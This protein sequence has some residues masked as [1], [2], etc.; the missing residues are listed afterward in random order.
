VTTIADAR[1]AP[2]TEAAVDSRP[3]Y[4]QVTRDQW[5]AFWAVFLGWVVDSFD[6]NILAFIVIDIKESF[7]IDNTLLYTGG[8]GGLGMNRAFHDI[9]I[10]QELVDRLGASMNSGRAIFLYGAAGTGKSARRTEGQQVF[11]AP[12]IPVLRP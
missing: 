2:T 8:A 10:D 4:R 1:P 11:Q 12:R 6:F 9:V 3:W 5:R 7:D